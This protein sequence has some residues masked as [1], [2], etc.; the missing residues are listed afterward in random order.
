MRFYR[1]LNVSFWYENKE[2][3][4]FPIDIEEDDF[5]VSVIT[6]A[7]HPNLK[8][9]CVGNLIYTCNGGV[10]AETYEDVKDNQQDCLTDVLLK[11]IQVWDISEDGVPTWKYV[12]EKE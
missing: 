1:W 8:R 10:K 7:R 4:L 9:G 12:F 11:K 2:Y 5:E 3:A 6:Q